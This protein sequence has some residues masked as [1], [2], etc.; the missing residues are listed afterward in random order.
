MGNENGGGGRGYS[1]EEPGRAGTRQGSRD[2]GQRPRTNFRDRSTERDQDRRSY[3]SYDEDRIGAGPEQ[4]YRRSPGQAGY[5]RY[6]REDQGARWNEGA[7][8]YGRGQRER[9]GDYR[10]EREERSDHRDRPQGTGG[11]YGSG[12]SGFGDRER[13]EYG[14][15]GRNWWDKT[16]D[17]VQSWFGDDDAARRRRVDEERSHRGRGPEG[18]RR[19]DERIREDVHDKLTEDWFLDA[20]RISVSVEN[21]DVTLA[22]LVQHRRDKRRAEDVVEEISGV[23]HVQNNLRVEGREAN[24][25]T[26]ETPGQTDA[27]AVSATR[28]SRMNP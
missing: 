17:E 2:Y 8:E 12:M 22:G 13:G 21:G 15:D 4:D 24:A 10:W 6:E 16:S 25:G 28:S 11:Y 27:G 18:Y 20:S 19:S 14:R 23:R 7:S 9:P 26:A 5:G 1:W 3:Y